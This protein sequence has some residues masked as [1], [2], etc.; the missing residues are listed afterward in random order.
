MYLSTLT[1]T[2]GMLPVVLLCYYL[3]PARARTGF[4]L[5]VSLV[6][7]GWGS[8]ARLLY[9]A[10][11]VCFIY[12]AGLLLEHLREKRTLCSMLLAGSAVGLT[13]A[14]VW[15]R[16][17]AAGGFLFPFGIAVYTLQ[18]LGYLIGVYR[19]RHPA[20]VRFHELA[21]YLCLFPIVFAG[22]LLNYVEFQ[23][24]LKSRKCTVIELGGGLELFIRGL[25]EKVVL[26]DTFGY[27]FRELRQTGEMSM[28][29]AWITTVAFSMYLYFEL[30]GYTEMA[31]GLCRIFGFELPRSFSQPFF[32]SGV[33][34]FMQNWNITLL[35]WFQTNFR[36]FLFGRLQKK[37][38]KYAA[39]ILTWVLIGAWYGLK[40]QFA[41]WG[42]TI[43]L[44]L[45]L[46]QL[47]L[48]PLLRGRFVRGMVLT[49]IILQFTW[50][51]FF[52]DHLGDAVSVWRSMV[53]FGKGL[54]DSTGI[55]FF[56]S[57]IALL[58]LGLYIAT[59]LFRNITERIASTE[60][61]KR[62][63]VLRPAAHGLLLL[64]C[65]ASMLYGQS[66]QG[67]WLHI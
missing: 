15:V 21:L 63:Q 37:W 42:L 16:S 57:Y 61:G 13:A 35:L 1:F 53:G 33:T 18:G 39:L 49:N 40:P 19:G 29:T 30:L 48:E 27:I 65:L 26:A 4:L 23:E 64:F 56:T 34:G 41:V 52:A 11:C 14:M 55:Y 24:Q 9:P 22:P 25:A 67:L 31:R 38:Q 58:L 62:I 7:Y 10:A 59:D 8:P 5:A 46:D 17:A 28:L 60:F 45:T 50:V 2:V 20:T 36:Y 51:M 32:N 12:G 54:A 47:V 43:G 66:L 44:L 6:I 3:I